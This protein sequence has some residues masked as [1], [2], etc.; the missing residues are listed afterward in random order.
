[1]WTFWRCFWGER[2]RNASSFALSSQSGRRARVAGVPATGGR[3]PG[4]LGGAAVGAAVGR[5]SSVSPLALSVPWRRGAAGAGRPL[6]VCSCISSPGAIGL[7]MPAGIPGRP[8]AAGLPLLGVPGPALSR[9]I[10]LPTSSKGVTPGRPGP[11]E[12]R[13][14]GAA[15][16]LPAVPARTGAGAPGLWGRE[17]GGAGRAAG[18]AGRADG[19]ADRA[20]GGAGRTEGGGGGLM[21]GDAALITGAVGLLPGAAGAVPAGW[22][23]PTSWGRPPPLTEGGRTGAPEARGLGLGGAGR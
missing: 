7:R 21:E 17:E 6:G 20:A 2:L 5:T 13:E 14:P 9:R 3:K 8:G 16:R 1:M 10:G 19:G 4:R 23:R 12:G 18:G 22:G 11:G 15:G